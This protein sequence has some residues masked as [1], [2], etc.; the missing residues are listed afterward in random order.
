MRQRLA[1]VSAIP[2]LLSVAELAALL[3]CTP[4]TVYRLVERDV[5]WPVRVPAL[6]RVLFDLHD[7]EALLKHGQPRRRGR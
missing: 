5:I 3:H 2:R 4:R 7:V 6:R 1:G